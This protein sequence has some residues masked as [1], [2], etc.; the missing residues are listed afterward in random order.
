M[1]TKKEREREDLFFFAEV[2]KQA[3]RYDDMLAAVK[4]ITQLNAELT[5][6]ERDLFSFAY[7]SIVGNKRTAWR[8]IYSF[9]QKA[10][11]ERHDF[12]SMQMKEYRHKVEVEL[13]NLCR[14]LF[15]FLDTYLIPAAKNSESKALYFKMK[16]DYQRYLAEILSDK[17]KQ[18]AVE[19]ALAAYKFAS[20]VAAELEAT[21]PIRLGVALNFS[22]LCYEFL[23]S[24]QEACELAKQAFDEAIGE[25]QN[26]GADKDSVLMVQLLRENYLLWSGQKDH[27]PKE[28]MKQRELSFSKKTQNSSTTN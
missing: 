12:R 13:V 19:N 9:E 18:E 8:T 3:E 24:K 26:D 21:N 28:R 4:K 16:G 6:K 27:I 15:H 23:D 14:D 17:E 25:I 7:K 10:E 20:A 1:E 5:P 2:A 11:Q 22:V